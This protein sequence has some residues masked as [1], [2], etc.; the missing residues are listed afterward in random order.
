M[1]DTG[2]TRLRNLVCD[3]CILAVAA[4]FIYAAQS[5]II[6]PR[7]FVF[8]VKN[9]RMMPEELLH[10][11]ALFL[12]WWEVGAATA[13]IIPATRRAGAIL[14]IGMLLMFIVAVSYAALYKGYNISCGCF[15]KGST[16]A[17]LKTIALDIGL[18]L[19]TIIGLLPRKKV[20]RPSG[21]PVMEVNVAKEV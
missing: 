2:K 13:L 19:A 11:V 16:S 18:I 10:L 7:Q 15:G 12:P 17:G 5:K 4:T 1:T 9:Y 14:I 8:D 3:L 20:E 6:E 21:F